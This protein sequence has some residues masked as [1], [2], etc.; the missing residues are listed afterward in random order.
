MIP[1]ISNPYRFNFNC[2]IITMIQNDIPKIQAELEGINGVKRVI[3]SGLG[4]DASIQESSFWTFKLQ[5]RENS[6]W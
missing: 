5:H 2:K 3:S 1:A 6:S 4:P